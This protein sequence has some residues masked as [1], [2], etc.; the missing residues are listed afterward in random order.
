MGEQIFERF[1]RGL[2]GKF[3]HHRCLNSEWSLVCL[4]PVE[5]GGIG[6]TKSRTR[7]K[8]GEP[9]PEPAQA[10][11]RT[12]CPRPIRTPSA[13]DGTQHKASEYYSLGINIGSVLVPDQH[14]SPQEATVGIVA[15]PRKGAQRL[16]FSADLGFKREFV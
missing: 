16:D 13:K 9:V 6:A 5:T 7:G 3:I 11:G 4:P 1:F 8:G 12:S 14:H 10:G 15:R 2:V